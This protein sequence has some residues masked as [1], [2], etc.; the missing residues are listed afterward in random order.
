MSDQNKAFFQIIQL[1][2]DLVVFKSY[3]FKQFLKKMIS[4]MNK[5]VP[6]DACLIYFFDRE[7]NELTLVGSK[8]THPKLMGKVVLK[9]GEGITGWVA[10]NEKTVLLKKQAYKDKRFKYVEELPE[11]TYEAFLS[12]PIVDKKGIIG[13]VNLQNKEPYDFSKEQVKT[14]EAM[15]HIIASAFEK[16]LLERK[17]DDL[18][19]QLMERKLVEKA[20]G[21]LMKKQ[22]LSEKQSYDLIRKE[23]M[24]K[25][26]SMKD[27]AEAVILLYD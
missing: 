27:I 10:E 21:I 6:V 24:R 13:V 4:L 15:V 25:R 5:I 9:K 1:L 14:I 17:V 19:T 7:R 18:Q 2:S 3:D 26:K 16:V 20:K 22:G 12:V 8:K 23:A 11:D